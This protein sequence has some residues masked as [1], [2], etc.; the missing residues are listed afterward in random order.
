MDKNLSQIIG[1]ADHAPPSGNQ[2]F[3]SSS[4]RQT[5]QLCNFQNMH[6]SK[7]DGFTRK[8]IISL[9]NNEKNSRQLLH[10][11]DEMNGFVSFTF[12]ME[13]KNNNF[14]CTTSSTT[15]FTKIQFGAI[16]DSNFVFWNFFV[17]LEYLY[18][19]CF[20]SSSC[21]SSSETISPD[22]SY[23]GKIGFK[24]TFFQRSF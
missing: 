9:K 22:L 23:I 1:V 7:W 4:S 10:N 18:Y 15:L 6:F 16:I 24:I 17:K 8:K 11:F 2:K 20:K 13:F 14:F 21:D 5:L 12:K 19:F 3:A